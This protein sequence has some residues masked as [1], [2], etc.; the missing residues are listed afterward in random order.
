MKITIYIDLL[1][2]ILKNKNFVFDVCII[3]NE[4]VLLLRMFL[5]S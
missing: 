3:L 1:I 5:L 4:D 2:T